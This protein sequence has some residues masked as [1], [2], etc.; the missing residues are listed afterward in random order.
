MNKKT[1]GHYTK[2]VLSKERKRDKSLWVFGC[3]QGEKYADNPKYLFEYALKNGIN[4]VW[5]TKSSNVYSL[6]KKN[7][8]PVEMYNS[9]RGINFCKKAGYAIFNIDVNDINSDLLAGSTLI[10]LWHG[11]P[12]KRIRY[13]DNITF[14]NGITKK[15]K[16]R[17]NVNRKFFDKYYVFS[18]SPVITDIYKSAFRMD[19]KDEKQIIEIGQSRNDCFFDGSL[20]FHKYK[21]LKYDYLISYLPT[22]RDNGRTRMEDNVIFDL[23]RLENFCEEYNC[24]F[25]IKKHFWHKNEYTDLSQ[26][27]HIIDE[28]TNNKIDTQELLYNT[29]ILIT[30][31]SSC[32]IDYLLLDRPVIFYCYDYTHYLKADRGLYFNYQDVT[33]GS[34]SYNF[35]QLIDSLKQAI[36]GNNKYLDQQNRVKNFFYSKENQNIVSPRLIEKIKTL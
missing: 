7:N 3:W 6:L 4:A 27:S 26:Y 17:L 19:I 35:E 23:P 1:I 29:D 36:N 9:S 22:Y 32:Y 12:L 31:Y 16:I 33:P 10:N 24:L 11:V 20:E 28:T 5:I 15:D 8:M 21:D 13:D 2:L 34:H 14:K 18:T 30:D 25:L